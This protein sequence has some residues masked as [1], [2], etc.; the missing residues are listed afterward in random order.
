[1]GPKAQGRLICTNYLPFRV[2]VVPTFNQGCPKRPEFLQTCGTMEAMVGGRANPA[3]FTKELAE[4]FLQ[5]ISDAFS[6]FHI[7]IH[8]ASLK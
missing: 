5:T 7:N 2:K 3:L 1:M 4:L 8:D 6:V